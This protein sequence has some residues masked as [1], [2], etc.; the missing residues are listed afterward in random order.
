MNTFNGWQVHLVSRL[1]MI[2]K[3]LI[4][5]RRDSHGRQIE[6]LTINDNKGTLIATTVPSDGS[7]TDLV[8]MRFDDP[9][10]L[11]EVIKAFANLAKEKGF[12]N[13]DESF[14]KGKLEATEKHLD[15]MRTLVFPPQITRRTSKSN[16]YE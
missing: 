11:D 4:I 13:D 14:A 15:D 10:E 5:F 7:G 3:D 16:I 12:P 8:T 1:G 2:G 9:V 6:V